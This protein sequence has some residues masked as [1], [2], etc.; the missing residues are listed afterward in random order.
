MDAARPTPDG[1]A[2]PALAPGPTS[3][4]FFACS[5]PG[6][7]APPGRGR[8]TDRVLRE[9]PRRCSTLSL[10]DPYAAA[11]NLTRVRWRHW[12]SPVARGRGIDLRYRR[13]HP[14]IRVR[15]KAYRLR[16]VC[17][18]DYVYTRLRVRS[19]K[20]TRIVRLPRS[21]GD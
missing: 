2:P 20:K 14:R 12:G 4:R 13:P 8:G 11:A 9:R 10:D 1:Q 15:L 17:R 21:C 7:S 6:A 18:G 3:P 19:R 5:S 16:R